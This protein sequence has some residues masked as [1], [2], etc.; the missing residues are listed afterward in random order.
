MVDPSGKSAA[1][2]PSDSVL[3]KIADVLERAV[4]PL[5]NSG[6]FLASVVL[7]CMMF[8]TFFDV[9]G[10]FTLNKPITGS[11]ELTEFMMSILA[12][13]GIGYC[14]IRKG[15]IRVDLVLQYTSKK[16]TVWFDVVTY[17]ISC[18]FY[19]IL[20]WQCFNNAVSQLHSHLTSSVLFIPV[21]PFVFLLVAGTGI[22]TLI[23]LKDTLRSIDEVRKL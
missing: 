17:A 5:S 9:G 3:G 23:L 19:A 10:R 1:E 8:L 11:L 15:H 22:L 21:Y 4:K 2:M 7:A 16:A 18:L 12:S 13:F 14:A 20:T 6:L